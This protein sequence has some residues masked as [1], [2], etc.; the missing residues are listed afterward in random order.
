MTAEEV[1]SVLADAPGIDS[2]SVVIQPVAGAERT[3]ETLMQ[4][5]TGELTNAQIAQVDTLL[6]AEFGEV[7][8]G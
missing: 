6:A 2:G 5:R 8:T 4:I 7:S 1:R 3:G